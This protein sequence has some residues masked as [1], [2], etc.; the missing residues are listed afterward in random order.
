[1][2][3]KLEKEN[4]HFRVIL[5]QAHGVIG[6]FTRGQTAFKPCRCEACVVKQEIEKLLKE[7]V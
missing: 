2:P 4:A 7:K 3:T 5:E 6:C 1:M